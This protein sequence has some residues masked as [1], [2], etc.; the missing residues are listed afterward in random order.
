MQL[1]CVK[2]INMAQMCIVIE[3][4]AALKCNCSLKSW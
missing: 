3:S 2:D 1:C 4:C